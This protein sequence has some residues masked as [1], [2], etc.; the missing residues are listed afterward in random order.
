VVAADRMVTLAVSSSS[1]TVGQDGNQSP[2]AVALIAGDTLLGFA[3]R[4]R[5]RR[6][7]T[8]R[9]LALLRS[10][11]GWRLAMSRCDATSSRTK[12]SPRRALTCRH[13]TATM[14]S[15]E[16]RRGAC[17]TALARP[18][19]DA[20]GPSGPGRRGAASVTNVTSA[21]ECSA[22]TVMR[23]YPRYKS[24]AACHGSR[25]S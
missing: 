9:V 6:N 2:Y 13:P 11:N 24:V 5:S 17:R 18:A 20:A 25:R 16:T 8:E 3:W 22:S 12:S 19:V 1:S 21:G 4:R 23:A 14:R 10:P 15:A 7:S